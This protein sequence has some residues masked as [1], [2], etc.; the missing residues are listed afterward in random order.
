MAEV[1]AQLTQPL[2]TPDVPADRSTPRLL[3]PDSEDN[4]RALFE[5]SHW[6]DFLPI[7]LPTE[8]RVVAMLD[9]TSH[10]PNEVIG[11]LRPTITR[12]FWEF[13]VEKV[14]VNAVMA[15]ARP[16]YFPTILATA[17]AVALPP[18]VAGENLI[19]VADLGSSLARVSSTTSWATMTIVN[20][21]VR[22]EIGMNYGIGA[23]APYNRANATIGRAFGLL[24]QNLQGG[25]VPGETYMGSLGNP[26]AYNSTCFAENEQRSP[27]DPLHVRRGFSRDESTV[28]IAS[29]LT[30]GRM[31]DIGDLW[32][33]TLAELIANIGVLVG[34]AR[35]HAHS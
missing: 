3:E 34:N 14:A 5:R 15:G 9:G 30:L 19:D 12:E 21:P 4:L 26:L 1:V 33:E 35:R 16:E 7:V 6:T 32:E 2:A 31:H 18:G 11:R 29:A 23:L 27:W 13:T 17:A 10:N 8:E 25:S 20:G 24:S 22:D 28:T